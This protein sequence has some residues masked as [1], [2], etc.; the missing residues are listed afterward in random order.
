MRIA[1][2]GSGADDPGRGVS[3]SQFQS[4]AQPAS[5]NPTI[6]ISQVSALTCQL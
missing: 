1:R 6:K 5:T 2:S 4:T 3:Q